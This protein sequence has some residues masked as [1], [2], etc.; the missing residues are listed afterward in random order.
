[1]LYE[2]LLLK[3]KPKMVALIVAA[4]KL[5]RQAFAIATHNTR[6]DKII[7]FLL[8]L[9]TVH[10]ESTHHARVS[11]ASDSGLSLLYSAPLAA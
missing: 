9:N 7:T 3:G 10:A 6:F 11:S 1:L 2:R 4:H 8:L 5:L